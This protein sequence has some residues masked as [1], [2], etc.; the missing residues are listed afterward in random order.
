MARTGTRAAAE[1]GNLFERLE[2]IAVPAVQRAFAIKQPWKALELSETDRCLNV[3]HLVLRCHRVHPEGVGAA[4]CLI[5][6]VR[7]TPVA[8]LVVGDEHAALAGHQQLRSLKRERGTVPPAADRPVI[9]V[10]T[11][12]G[13]R[14]LQYEEAVLVRDRADLPNPSRIAIQMDRDHGASKG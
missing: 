13:R 5:Q 8:V 10:C 1:K 6:H 2:L 3:R 11:D 12:G 4:P 14:I 7:R 9:R